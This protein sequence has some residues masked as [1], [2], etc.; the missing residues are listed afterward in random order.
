MK[1]DAYTNIFVGKVSSWTRRDC[2]V[3]QVRGKGGWRQVQRDVQDQTSH[4]GRITIHGILLTRI[5]CSI[6]LQCKQ[7]RA[8]SVHACCCH[9]PV[10][11]M[12]VK[13]VQEPELSTLEER[14]SHDLQQ[15]FGSAVA[16]AKV[17]AEATTH[18]LST[19]GL[20]FIIMLIREAHCSH[21]SDLCCE[22][23][24]G[25]RI[26]GA[27]KNSMTKPWL[28]SYGWHQIYPACVN[29][30]GLCIQNANS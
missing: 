27:T 9:V 5:A 10:C 4:I 1:T 16:C 29:M 25:C 30:G 7:T 21:M 15:A 6:L 20:L 19:R 8:A 11:Y 12:T 24:S 13:S 23:T 2:P 26:A 3:S 22:T 18:S 17:R 14:L 28:L